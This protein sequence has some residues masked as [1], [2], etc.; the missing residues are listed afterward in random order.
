MTDIIE[1]VEAFPITIPR[2]VPYLG[3]LGEI[4]PNQKGYFIRPR[5][6]TVY[7]IH[8]HSM[9]VKITTR[10]GVVGWGEALCPVSPQVSAKIV[11]D[12]LG[13]L[14]IGRDPQDVVSIYEDLYSSMQVRGYHGGF[15]CDALAAIDI[16]LWDIKGK[17]LGLPICKILGGKRRDKI[18]A[19]VSGLPKA[20]V[21]ERAEFA[22]EWIEKGYDAVKFAAAVSYEGEVKEAKAI[23]KA[24]GDGYNI[25]V[26]MHWRYSALEAIALIDKL[27]EYDIYLAEAPVHPQDIDGQAFV[28]SRVKTSIGIGEELRNIYEFRERF[29]RRCMNVIQPEM[30]RLGITAF[31]NVC[32]MAK[33]YHCKVMPHASIGVGV[34]QAASLQVS[35]AVQDLPYH[36]F[37]HSTFD[38]S[39]KFLKGNMRCE[40]GFFTLPDGAGLGVEPIDDMFEF[41]II[42]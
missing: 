20:T 26:D 18:P 8:D 38:T 33:A 11:D 24:I 1:K 31:W 15:F 21:E 7:S 9:L 39:L 14:I 34:F 17:Q 35:A 41:I 25:L 22:L 28:T 29:E 2:K 16:A 36:E 23:R 13:P 37:Q 10:D 3:P 12:L 40:N 6:K 27:S 42:E 4:V 5:N 32:Q 19:Y 30:G